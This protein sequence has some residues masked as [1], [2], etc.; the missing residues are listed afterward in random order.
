MFRGFHCIRFYSN[1]RLTSHR[2]TAHAVAQEVQNPVAAVRQSRPVESLDFTRQVRRASCRDSGA[3]A[4]TH[5]L[6]FAAISLLVILAACVQ[7]GSKPP[8]SAKPS[9]IQQDGA[10]YRPLAQAEQ[11]DAPGA[12]SAANKT[13]VPRPGG[14]NDAGDARPTATFRYYFVHAVQAAQPARVAEVGS[15]TNP[16]SALFAHDVPEREQLQ[17]AM[18]DLLARY[19]DRHDVSGVLMA[20]SNRKYVVRVTFIAGGKPRELFYD[21]GRWVGYTRIHG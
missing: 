11:A 1:S 4:M 13:F 6:R 20:G 3:I 9:P 17:A 5:A 18:N 2:P 15:G 7:Q 16:A 21:V 10:A 12:V 8:P 14:G 19:P